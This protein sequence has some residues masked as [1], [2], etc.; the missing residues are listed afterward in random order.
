[1]KQEFNKRIFT[2]KEFAGT[3]NLA[4]YSIVKY[5]KERKLINK[6]DLAIVPNL[7]LL[8]KKNQVLQKKKSQN[9]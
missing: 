7:L 1:M 6:S 9:T 8:S 5:S 4:T 2:F 3:V